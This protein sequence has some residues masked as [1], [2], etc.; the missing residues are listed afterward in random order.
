MT[1]SGPS[2]SDCRQRAAGG[3]LTVRC[4]G[5]RLT[6]V[7]VGLSNHTT[8]LFLN[9][10]LL[11]CLLAHSFS[12]LLML[13]ELD[14]SHN[15]LSSL[16]PGCFSG[17]VSSLR[18][19]DLS[20][21]QLIVLDHTVFGGLKA[22]ANLTYNPWHC[23]CSMQMVMAQLELDGSSLDKVIC[24]T[25]DL[26]NVGTV[27]LPLV[28]LVEDWDLCQSVLR[29]TDVVTLVTMLL[30]FSMLITYLIY[31]IQKNEVIIHQHFDHLKFLE[32]RDPFRPR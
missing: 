28:L 15:Q 11:R 13:T 31:Y 29:R 26:P 6:Q 25:T 7:P 30:W 18:Y 27:G 32:S 17:L 21:N 2:V 19:L 24:Q 10:N 16:E 1:S 12:D 22:R 23:N 4:S 3:G 9:K 5:L 14:L 20:Y 8:R